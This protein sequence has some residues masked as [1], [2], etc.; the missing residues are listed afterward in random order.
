MV[1]SEA[2]GTHAGGERLFERPEKLHRSR[3]VA[4]LRGGG[5]CAHGAAGGGR[6]GCLCGLQR[7]AL[8]RDH[9]GTRAFSGAA[10]RSHVTF[11]G[12][13]IHTGDSCCFLILFR[14]SER[15]D[16]KTKTFSSSLFFYI[17]E[18]NSFV[19]YLEN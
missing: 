13:N 15:S 6:E 1:V 7:R 8:L 5:G 18:N 14:S 3:V 11:S 10:P 4:A 2:G 16:E 19:I 12:G 17:K 9:G